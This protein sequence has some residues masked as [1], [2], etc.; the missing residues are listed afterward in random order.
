MKIP[1]AGFALLAHFSLART[2]IFRSCIRILTN[3]TTFIIATRPHWKNGKKFARQPTALLN[4]IS[5]MNLRMAFFRVG[6]LL[7]LGGAGM[8]AK[9]FAAEKTGVQ[10]T[11]GDDKLRVE[12]NGKLFTEYYFKDVPR[13]FCYPLLGPGELPMTREWPMKV[14]EDHRHHRSFWY[15]HGNV[16]GIDFWSE[17]KG[18]GKTVHEKFTEIKSGKKFGVI[19]SQNKWVAPDGTMVCTDDRTLKI[20]N[21][22]ENERLFDFEITLHA[23][24]EKEVVF[25]DTKEGS[26]AIRVASSMR[27]IDGKNK[28]GGGRIALS[29]GIFDN[30]ETALAARSAKHEDSTWGKR[31]DWCDYSGPV[32]GKMVGIAIFDSPKNPRHPTWWHVRDYGLFAANPFG[33]HEF[34]KQPKGA[35]NLTIPA[36]KS[37]TFR[38]RF[39]LHEGDEKQAKVAEHYHEFAKEK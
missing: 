19:K 16:N 24:K 2:D 14:G 20:Y 17:E 9:T 8:T 35:G 33:I 10:I 5:T 36:G 31:A 30:S 26:M 4:I 28:A 7:V 27:V 21:R 25:G 11:S 39:Y 13:P 32:D 18:F 34:E 38:Y 3:T 22:P 23:P 15:A 1:K 37:V 12:I 6:L 29:T